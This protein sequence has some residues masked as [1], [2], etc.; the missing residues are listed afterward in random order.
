MTAAG[1]YLEGVA[2]GYWTRLAKSVSGPSAIAV[3]IRR[4]LLST[5]QRLLTIDACGGT[6]EVLGRSSPFYW[7]YAKSPG[8]MIRGFC[9]A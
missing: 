3:Q 6:I 5:H 1:R 2:S 7:F 8:V 9:F 4:P